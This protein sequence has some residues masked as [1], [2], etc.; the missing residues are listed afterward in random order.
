MVRVIFDD[1]L[2]LRR[3]VLCLHQRLMKEEVVEEVKG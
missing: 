1:N 2:D 3:Q